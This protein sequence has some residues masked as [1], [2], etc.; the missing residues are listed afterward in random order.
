MKR[1]FTLLSGLALVGL[2]VAACGPA[3]TPSTVVP[4]VE[5]QNTVEVVVTQIVAGTPV[6]VTATPAPVEPTATVA[7]APT[8]EP[9]KGGTI[10]FAAPSD[11]SLWD[12]KFTN[13]NYS[14]YAEGQVYA[15]LLQNSPD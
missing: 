7:E 5:V 8:P 10:V 9:V 6:V 2:L 13:D 1:A 14:L 15:T 11:T 4:T 3:P 12:P